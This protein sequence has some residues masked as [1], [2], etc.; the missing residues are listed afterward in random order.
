MEQN[1]YLSKMS[2][3]SLWTLMKHLKNCADEAENR[4]QLEKY[5]SR[6]LKVAAEIHT[7]TEKIFNN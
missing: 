1:K 4:E 7:R 6:I 3:A 5:A 2:F